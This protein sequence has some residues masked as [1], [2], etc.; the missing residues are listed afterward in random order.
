MCYVEEKQVK[1]TTP[2]KDKKKN[3]EQEARVS[4]ASSDSDVCLMTEH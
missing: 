2:T 1:A 3:Q 4:W